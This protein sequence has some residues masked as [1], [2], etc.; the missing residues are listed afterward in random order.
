MAVLAI[1]A[2]LMIMSPLTAAGDPNE[3]APPVAMM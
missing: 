3:P 1:L 2:A